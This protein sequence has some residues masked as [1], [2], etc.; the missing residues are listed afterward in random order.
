MTDLI[1]NSRSLRINTVQFI[2]RCSSVHCTCSCTTLQGLSDQRDP[3]HVSEQLPGL[4]W[5]FTLPDRAIINQNQYSH[6]GTGKER[7][8][9]V[10]C[11]IFV[12]ESYRTTWSQITPW[13][14]YVSATRPRLVHCHHYFLRSSQIIPCLSFWRKLDRSLISVGVIFRLLLD[15]LI[16]RC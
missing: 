9:S 14:S 15:R 4:P 10:G 12:K 1:P 2:S 11:Y 16:A 6:C 13:K 3:P 7:H 5:V 8:R